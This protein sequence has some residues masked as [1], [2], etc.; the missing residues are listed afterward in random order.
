MEKKLLSA[1]FD[2]L[3]NIYEHTV[4]NNGKI[5]FNKIVKETGYDKALVSDAIEYLYDK[6]MID[7]NIQ[8]VNNRTGWYYSIG[9]DFKGFIEGLYNT[10]QNYYD[11]NKLS[12]DFCVLLQIY[13]DNVNNVLCTNKRLRTIMGLSRMELGKS[14]DKLSDLCMIIMEYKS[15]PQQNLRQYFEGNA[16]DKKDDVSSWQVPCW[17]VD[18]DILP[19]LK[20]LHN[21]TIKVKHNDSVI[22]VFEEIHT[23]KQHV[24]EE[25]DAFTLTKKK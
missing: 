17:F 23:G 16:L 12:T 2:I 4:V 10:V 3:L 6:Q 20:G 11:K 21:S 18:E 5:N 9:E 24:L 13:E 15:L 7:R 19:F 14:I 1:E 8:K 22:R 25:Y